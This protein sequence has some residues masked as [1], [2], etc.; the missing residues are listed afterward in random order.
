MSAHTGAWLKGDGPQGDVVVSSRLR[1]ARN[2]KGFKFKGRMAADEEAML[3][4]HIG[5]R[6]IDPTFGD[7]MEYVRLN[8]IS[9]LERTLL[10]E[11]HLISREHCDGTGPRGVAFDLGGRVSIM[12]NEEDHLRIQVM[13]AGLALREQLCRINS[14]DDIL[15]ER[16]SFSFDRDFGY[17]TTCPTNVGTGL[18]VSVM[19]HLPALALSKHVEKVF[20]AVAKVNLAVRGFFG[21]GSQ[22][23]GDFYQIS[24][25][26]TL[27]I[28]QDE[29]LLEL[30]RVLPKIIEYERDVRNVLLQD[31]RRILEDKV[32]RAI[33]ILRSARTIS[34]EEVMTHLS[35]VRMGV[36]MKLIDDV[37]IDRVN[38]LFLV[39]QPG[40]VQKLAEKELGPEE[41]DVARA[42]LIRKELQDD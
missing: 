18:R 3:E 7:T 12:V 28:S 32:F 38:K 9:E 27:G 1:L 29:A 14:I 24:N 33:A 20:N 39:V 5:E 16:L 13:A 26:I 4:S 15:T 10:V 34:S 6:V 31:E 19:L 11:R 41:R 40:H 8:D 36:F 2:L 23:Q 21:E 22:A 17:L 35:F 37:S 25:Q 30:N 42:T